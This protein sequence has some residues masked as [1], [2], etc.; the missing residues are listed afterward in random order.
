MKIE[1]ID[2]NLLRVFDELMREGRVTRVAEKLGISQPAVSHALRRLRET[3]GDELFLRQP[4]GMAPTPYALQLADPVAQALHL[5]RGALHVQASF[6]PASS[7]RRF[8]L[9]MSDVG[10]LYFLPVLMGHLVS[11]AP[12]VT[13][14]IV[15]VADPDL[16]ERMASGQVDLALGT[17]PGLQAGFYRQTLFHQRYVVLLRAGHPL[18]R[19]AGISAARYRRATH[20]Q[21]A[22]TGTGHGR[23]EDALE[24]QGLARKVALTVP[25]YVAL[26][27]VL[28]DTDLMATVPERFAERVCQPFGLVARPLAVALPGSEIAQ[29]WHAHLH[30]D[31]GHRWLRV[32]V[33]ELFGRQPMAEAAASA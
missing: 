12:A 7:Q 4:S 3:L 11:V 28:A 8:T 29:H 26:G 19:H 21:V 13:L 10:E 23:V 32:Q 20:V 27:Q 17:L 15:P 14:K 25:H 16:R 1:D 33:A 18:A 22:A 2:L 30:R 9:A 5:L 6:D 24:N 31:P